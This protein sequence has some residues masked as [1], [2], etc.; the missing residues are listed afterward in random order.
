MI[1]DTITLVYGAIF[2][3][4]LLLVEGIFL[5]V[6]DTRRQAE[7]AS[8]RRARL[9]GFRTGTGAAGPPVTLRRASGR[10]KGPLAS[11]ARTL[12]QSGTNMSAWRFLLI[13]G[14]LVFG[15]WIAVVELT[16]ASP[17]YAIPL[18]VILGV[19]LPLLVVVRRRHRRGRRFAEQLPDTLDMIVRSLRAG[20]PIRAAMGL[21]AREMPQPA[22][23]EF[24]TVVDEMTYG[25]E[26]NEALDNLCERVDHTDLHYTVVAI[27]IQHASGGNLAEV[28]ANLSAVIRDRFRLY[29]KVRALSAEGKLSGWVIAIVPFFIALIMTLNKPSY[30]VEAAAHPAFPV[31]A[32]FAVFLYVSAIIAIYK[33]VNIRV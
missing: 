9:Q 10:A 11:L 30:Y 15:I 33:I 28:L 4:V 8:S 23:P 16:P 27:N 21:V 7:L 25:L 2:L 26:L 31:V 17:L 14:A 12:E 32:A 13:A 24:G 22:G 5:F 20:H 3:A 18:A 6:Y 19:A 29:K 1:P